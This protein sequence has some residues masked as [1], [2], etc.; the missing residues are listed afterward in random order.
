MPNLYE[1]E[2]LE[3]LNL[4]HNKITEIRYLQ[5]CTNLTELDLSDNKLSSTKGLKGLKLRHLNINANEI[6]EIDPDFESLVDLMVLQMNRN[7]IEQ[8]DHLKTLQ[9][10]RLLDLGGNNIRTFNEIE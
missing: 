6:T 2:S 3:Q 5:K 9:K 7:F 10:L 1:F 4:N 8:L